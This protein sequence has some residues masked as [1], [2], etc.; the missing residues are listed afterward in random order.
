VRKELIPMDP[1][2]FKMVCRLIGAARVVLEL[3]DIPDTGKFLGFSLALATA[4]K[5]EEE[6][7]AD[8]RV[9]VMK[10]ASR[11]G[12]PVHSIKTMRPSEDEKQLVVE[13]EDQESLL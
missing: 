2:T 8:Y 5:I 12:L 13:I 9:A 3:E 6:L 7:T 11:A 1:D 10:A 4:K